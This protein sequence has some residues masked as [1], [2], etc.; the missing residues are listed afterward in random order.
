MRDAQGNEI[1]RGERILDANGSVFMV[2]D[3]GP[4]TMHVQDA[5]TGRRYTVGLPLFLK[6][7]LR[8]T[9]EEKKAREK[10]DGLSTPKERAV[11]FN[12]HIGG[13]RR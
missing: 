3:V 10:N 1:Q 8:T 6:V 5:K 9:E 11:Y 13:R 7:P 2:K 4:V 12:K